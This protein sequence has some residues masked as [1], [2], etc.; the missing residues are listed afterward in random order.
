M[1]ITIKEK[2]KRV[3]AEEVLNERKRRLLKL[4]QDQ[5]DIK[6][7]TSEYLAHMEV[8]KS[9]LSDLSYDYKVHTWTLT[10]NNVLAADGRHIIATKDHGNGLIETWHL[11]APEI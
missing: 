11:D 1:S 10:E 3:M 5:D 2:P 4:A 6:A 8:D 9:E 7:S